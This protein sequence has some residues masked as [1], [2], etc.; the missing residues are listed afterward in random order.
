MN[1]VVKE[2]TIYFFYV[3]IL[4]LISYGNRDNNAYLVLL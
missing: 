3:A 2:L 1:E 4:F